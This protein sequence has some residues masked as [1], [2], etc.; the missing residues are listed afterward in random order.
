VTSR[1]SAVGPWL[2]SRG[3]AP[4]AHLAARIRA[5][6]DRATSAPDAAIA[7][8]LLDAAEVA[9]RALLP[10]GCLTRESALELLAVD[11]LVTYAFEAA[12]DDPDALERRAADALARI[13]ALGGASHA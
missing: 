6:T 10:D 3:P 13:A 7:D 9:M 4:P 1:A 2:E 8:R 12:A 5:L 11:A